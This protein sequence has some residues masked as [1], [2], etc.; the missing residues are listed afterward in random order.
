MTY[1]IILVNVYR[2]LQKVS[3][4]SVM[5]PIL[6]GV[7]KLQLLDQTSRLVLF[8]LVIASFPQLSAEYASYD[9]KQLMYNVYTL[10]DLLMWGLIFWLS[11]RYIRA[12]IWIGIMIAVFVII[13]TFF[14]VTFGITKI[15]IAQLVCLSS[16]IQVCFVLLYFYDIYVRDD[17]LILPSLPMFWFAVALLFYAPVTYFHFAFFDSVTADLKIIHNVFNTLMYSIITVGFLQIQRVSYSS[18]NI[19]SYK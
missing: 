1:E 7:L 11:I 3:E 18:T 14:F 4:Y 5:L 2:A 15:F 9:M 19:T 10:F 16:F 6:V 8:L 17:R 12:R 13:S